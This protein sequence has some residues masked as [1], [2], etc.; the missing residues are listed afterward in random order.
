MSRPITPRRLLMQSL[1][2][3]LLSTASCAAL[4]QSGELTYPERPIRL[5]SPFPAGGGTDYV[6]R[7][8]ANRLSAHGWT[9]TVDNRAGA[10]GTIGAAEIA[11]ARANGYDLVI[12]QRDNLVFAP[13]FQTVPYD[14]VRDFQPVA[15][16]ARTPIIIVAAADGKYQHF[17]DV[18]RAAR[19]QPRSVSIGSSGHGSASHIASELLR[20]R[21]NI[22]LQHVP[23]RGSAPALAD[24]A[25]GQIDLAGSSIASTAGL[26]QAGKLRAL[27]VVSNSRSPLLPDVPALA[28]L[29]FAD[30]EVQSWYGLFA[31]RGLSASIT[32][33][34]HKEVNRVLQEPEVIALLHKQGLDPQTI[35][36]DEF[37]RFVSADYQAIEAVLTETGIRQP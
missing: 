29:G 13:H 25:G 3:A 37:T 20:T 21:G 15:Y 32:Q 1:C 16:L 34:L 23:Y 36:L 5:V 14:T 9:V 2:V 6:A 24:L 30:V 22:E 19:A 8:L 28:E 31:P 27:A 26:R 12:G 33:L 7:L 35:A 4:A 11:R 18:V 17:A 10:N